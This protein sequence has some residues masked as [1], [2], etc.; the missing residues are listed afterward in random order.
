M[1]VPNGQS[2]TIAQSCVTWAGLEVKPLAVW[3]SVQ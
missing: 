2:G 3:E 1:K